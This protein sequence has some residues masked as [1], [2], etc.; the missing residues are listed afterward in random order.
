MTIKQP[1]RFAGRLL[2]RLVPAQDHD[3]LLGDLCEEYQRRR[4][5]AWYCLQILAAIIIGS[6][7]DIRG[8]KLLALRASLA[9]FVVMLLTGNASIALRD[10]LTGAGF[11]WHR[12]WVG[13]PLY[14]RYSYPWTYYLFFHVLFV[15]SNL[16]VGWA[17][18]RLH[19][20]HGL[21]MVFVFCGALAAL[22]AATLAQTAVL[23]GLSDHL[24][25]LTLGVLNMQLREWLFVILG[26]YLATRPQEAA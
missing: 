15:V 7:K 14:W 17:V 18:A 9:G 4:S 20:D 8:H 2:R 24:L 1:P 21:T 22:R 16:L 10:V 6:W 19:R 3:V 13:L 23:I 5:V 12:T 25:T 26:G 11:L